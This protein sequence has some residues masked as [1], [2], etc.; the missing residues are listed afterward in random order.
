[1][2]LILS[3]VVAVALYLLT[4]D[5][6][7]LVTVLIGLGGAGVGAAAPPAPG[8]KQKHINL[9]SEGKAIIKRADA[10]GTVLVRRPPKV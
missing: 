8:V 1:M 5:K 7:Y 2:P 4:G 6:T 3:V 9:V 10:T